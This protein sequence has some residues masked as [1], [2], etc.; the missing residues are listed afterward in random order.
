MK[1][2]AKTQSTEHVSKPFYNSLPLI[3]SYNDTAEEWPST[4][5]LTKNKSTQYKP[6]RIGDTFQA[7]IPDLQDTHISG[8]R[9]NLTLTEQNYKI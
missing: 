9:M 7:V 2:E 3:I 6:P 5:T 8:T 4:L 1:I